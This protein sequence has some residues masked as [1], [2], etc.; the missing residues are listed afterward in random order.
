MEPDGAWSRRDGGG[1][2]RGRGGRPSSLVSPQACISSTY[3][4]SCL[5][6]LE[7]GVSLGSWLRTNDEQFA[8]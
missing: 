4:T 7:R 6:V 8:Q 1:G 3:M 2:G 5:N